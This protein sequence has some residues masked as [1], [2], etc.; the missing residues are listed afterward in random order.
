[1][2]YQDYVIKDGKFV[3][4]FEE[5]YAQVPDPWEQSENLYFSSLSRRGVCYFID[6]FDINSVVEW[7][8][9][10][11]H[12]TNYIKQNTV[13]DIEILGIDVSKTAISRAR[14]TY[15]DIRFEVDDVS[16]VLN[17][18]GFECVF[19]SSITWYILEDGGIDRAFDAMADRFSGKNKF[20]IHVDN[21]YKGNTQRYG[22]EYFTSLDQFIEFC[23]FELLGKAQ[24]DI[25][26]QSNVET[27]AIFRI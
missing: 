3:G 12:T 22:R 8:C 24:I 16:N 4:E 7:G 23:P 27:V 17:Y 10:L 6:K 14:S 21:F 13:K 5:M 2:K 18:D 19:F 9:G 15:P 20:F 25:E 1:M 11:G 26:S